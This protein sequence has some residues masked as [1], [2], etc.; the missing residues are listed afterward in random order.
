MLLIELIYNLALLIALSV[1]SGFIDTRWKRNTRVGVIC[2]GILFGGA[3]VIGMLRPFVLAPGLIFDGRSVMI[4]LGGLFFGPW[5]AFVSCLMTIPF[6]LAQGGPGTLMGVLVILSSAGI[7]VGYHLSR[8][9]KSGEMPATMLYGFGLVV[10]LAMLAMTSALPRGMILPVLWQIGWPVML[11]YP[12]AT[13]L[14]GK[15]LSD[16]VA[17]DSYL[18][19]LQESEER[20]RELVEYANSVILRLAPD[21]TVTFINEFA[22]RFFGF[23]PEEILGRN[24]AGS[25]VPPSAS[26]TR[27]L[28]S[29]LSEL[30]TQPKQ[31]AT[32]EDENVRK[33]GTRCWLTWTNRG[34]LDEQ[35][36]CTA[37][38]CVGTD[39]SERKKAEAEK[40]RL[41]AQFLQAQK[42]ESIG[43]LAGGIAH[44]FNNIL[45]STMMHLSLLQQKTNLDP[46]THASLNELMGEAK[47]AA[48]L[49]RQLLLFSR[50]SI[51]NV[52][53]VDLNDV[54]DNLLKMLN[55]LI[56]EHISVRFDRHE[57][58]PP[59]EAD[60]GMIERVILNLS[61]NARDAMPEGGV[62]TIRVEPV[63]V[64]TD[65]LNQPMGM[66]PGLYVCLTVADTGCGMDST[67]LSHLFEP[68]FT[69]KEPGKGTG[70]GLATVHGVVAQHKGW[71]EVDSQVGRGSVFKVFLPAS[72]KPLGKPS[73]SI[74]VAP[75]HY[76]ATILL[77]EDETCVRRTVSQ[78][79]RRM[80]YRVLEAGNGPEAI[81][82][83]QEQSREIDLLFSDMVMPEGLSGLDLADNFKKEKAGLKVLI[84][85]GYN[86]EITGR[87]WPGGGDFAFLPKPY[88]LDVL[89]KIV[90]SLLS[91][92][93]PAEGNGCEGPPERPSRPPLAALIKNQDA[94]GNSCAK[95]LLGNLKQ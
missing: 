51:L 81:K 89:S 46:E 63:Q 52:Q 64:G 41:E 21:G 83:W 31:C 79:L 29:V 3:A 10:H 7:G 94:K 40:A 45:A 68:F 92:N 88:Q 66:K 42:M 70:L 32:F 95:Q 6:R 71:V 75:V 84:S 4:S 1:V 39:I 77:V 38:L 37:I 9:R 2:Q 59:V 30:G 19:S 15:I 65:K 85:S 93:I 50:S 80:G 55:R 12:L 36:H 86:A 27:N 60:A 48:S 25:I 35:G 91:R 73:Q 34:I 23:A 43:Q 28:S 87:K 56:G 58:L 69:T 61:I 8:V 82:V 18:A 76:Q 78:G 72:T 22:Q 47:R 74:P 17:R 57:S 53:V 13:V 62:L 90:A 33:D 67:T 16:Q 24:V 20:Y 44:D 26:G 49:T 14:I 11:V 5:A 54:V